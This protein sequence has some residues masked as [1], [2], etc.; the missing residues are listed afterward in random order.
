MDYT[1][2][3]NDLRIHMRAPSK[4]K[5]VGGHPVSRTNMICKQ[6]WVNSFKQNRD[7]LQKHYLQCSKSMFKW[8]T[9]LA[10]ERPNCKQRISPVH[11][12]A[13][14]SCVQLERSRSIPRDDEKRGGSGDGNWK[15]YRISITSLNVDRPGQ[16]KGC[17]VSSRLAAA[18]HGK[19]RTIRAGMKIVNRAQSNITGP[20]E[21]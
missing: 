18:C 20:S 16:P 17:I 13:L 19:K 3:M 12:R 11:L 14:A 2:F 9:C 6:S 7:S 10:H 5:R 4:G 1:H 21:N 8:N 15:N